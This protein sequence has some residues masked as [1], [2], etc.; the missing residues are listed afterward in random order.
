VLVVG[1][2][3]AGLTSAALLSRFGIEFLLVERRPK[4]S[5][6][7]KAHILNQRTM[8]IFR[9][10][11]LA[12]RVYS[13]G[14]P[15]A[16]M[17]KTAWYTSFAGPTP[18]HGREIGYID[19]MG[20]GL[21]A[22]RYDLASPCRLTNLAQNHL[23]PLM[24]QYVSDREPDRVHFCREVVAVR[25]DETQVVATI[26][27]VDSGIESLVSC[28]YLV[29]ADGGRTV[30]SLCG[31]SMTGRQA[32]V[33]M[34]TVHF[35]ANLSEVLPDPSVAMFRFINPDGPGKM[36]RGALVQ[37][38]GAGWGRGC[39]EW[40]LNYSIDPGEHHGLDAES[41]TGALRTMLGLSD[42]RISLRR[43][44]TWQL[45][46]VVAD[47]FREGRVFVVGDAAHRMPP[48]GG[49][50]LNSA[51]QDAHNL[52]WKLAYVLHGVAGEPLLQT[53]ED[54]RRPVDT[55]NTQH[56]LNSFFQSQGVDQALG[57]GPDTTPNEAWSSLATFFS[58]SP[59]S[60]LLRQQ[61]TLAINAKRNAYRA[62]NVEIG[63]G[64][65]AGALVADSG[66]E[67]CCTNSGSPHS[68]PIVDYVPSTKVGRR[69][70]HA[71]LWHDG[72]RISTVDLSDGRDF[73]LVTSVEGQ[74]YWR[75]VVASAAETL[76]GVP[77]RLAVVGADYHDLDGMWT[78]VREVS[79]A[80]G[81]LV[82]PDGH[83]AWRSAGAS[84]DRGILL[85]VLQR[86]LSRDVLG[87]SRCVADAS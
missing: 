34:V 1:G 71:W 66:P 42:L 27:D 4:A 58:Q 23:E 82:R 81:V 20:G 59:E 51:V 64:Y 72:R 21:D 47:R 55:F 77:L 17:A 78:R 65:E 12:D 76:S 18:L 86:A 49:L 67:E 22:A 75:D 31:I 3:A 35:D 41:V 57:I 56:A 70:P 80:G 62:L 69:V 33:D 79:G 83:V 45:E 19:A 28:D 68:D 13:A 11:G 9:E 6:L 5:S 29:A 2:G 40:V 48:A 85:A 46:A 61:V 7:P 8:E 73:V 60:Q 25:Q 39:T 63:F 36:H 32:I 30:G 87:H 37:M 15:S 14:A 53:Y 24:R 74:E 10:V 50:G 52:A 43:I 38:G 44:S 26:R 84:S 54:E 16:N